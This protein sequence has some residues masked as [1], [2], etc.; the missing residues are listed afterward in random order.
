MAG[1]GLDRTLF[2][3]MFKEEWRLHKSFVGSIGSG[4]FPVMIFIFSVVLA[5]TSPV[6]LK[7]IDI[8]TVLMILHVA[9]I[10]YGLMVGALGHIGEQVM[11]RRLGQ[12]NLLLQ[13]PQLYPLSFK[14]TMGIFYLKDALYYILYSI[15]PLVGGIAVG[16][17]L[18][19][20]T[21]GGVALLGLTLFL[22]FMMGMALSFL[23]SALSL[24]SRAG[25][26]A[27]G[28]LL[29]LLGVSVWPLG[30]IKA[31]YVLLPLGFWARYNVLYLLASGLVVMVFSV[32][33]VAFMRERFES[34][35]ET[36][37]QMLLA[38]EQRFSFAGDMNTLLAKEW[39]ELRRSGT[40]G[41]VVTGFL[42]PL[43]G[44]YIMVWIF[45][46]GMGV[47][48]DFNIVFYGCMV[49]FLGTMTYS[50]LTNL[51]PNEFMNVQPVSVDQVVK[52]KLIL[53]FLLTVGIAFGYVIVIALVNNDLALLPLALLVAGAT[54]VYVAAVTSWLTGLWTNTMMFDAKILG[55]FSGA[56][57]PPLIVI[58]I[59]SF[60][61]GS[62]PFPATVIILILSLVLLVASW[63]VFKLVPGKWR[64]VPFSFATTGTEKTSSI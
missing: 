14:R 15:L 60:W 55:K 26:A 23:L 21:F 13:L 63:Y 4:F 27:V 1:P 32:A 29:F 54:T 58:T 6:L 17:P 19:G 31:G 56:V 18:A 52:A 25:T 53:Y 59:A 36:H 9:A 47:P 45:N 3:A 5:V 62:D 28:L 30:L 37:M 49:G 10:L 34:P 50:W 22:T 8:P 11:T 35:Q 40:M 24:R 48:I 41:A 44:I 38:T 7:N 61:L 51:E 33:A 20:V 2:V 57:I 12:V 64:P 39:V 42:G 16:A 43:L 46:T